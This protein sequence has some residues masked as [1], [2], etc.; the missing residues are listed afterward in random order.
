MLF[1]SMGNCHIYEEH[2]EDMKEQVKRDPFPFPKV[3]IKNIRDD[4]NDYEV[5]DF[6]VTNYN[7]HAA[8]KMKMVA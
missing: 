6:E 4:I 5:D 1:R 2:I 3:A 8:I 7:H